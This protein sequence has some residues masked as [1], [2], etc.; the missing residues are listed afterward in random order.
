M[1]CGG[2]NGTRKQAGA[3]ECGRVFMTV[4]WLRMRTHNTGG[5]PFASSLC[6]QK[7]P[8]VRK[9][10]GNYFLIKST[11]LEK[12]RAPASAKLKIEYTTHFYS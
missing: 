7:T 12:L 9:A 8:S 6:R 4:S 10:T 3:Q 11:S 1:L 5:C 2:L